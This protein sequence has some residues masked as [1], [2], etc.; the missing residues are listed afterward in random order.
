MITMT[1]PLYVAIVLFA[2]VRF[3]GEPVLDIPKLAG[4]ISW[5]TIFFLAG[6]MMIA[7]AMGEATT[8]ISDWVMSW[9]APLVN[10]LS[11]F[12]MVALLAV[13]STV[14]TNICNNIPVGIVFTTVAVP[15]ALQMG[16]NP[17]IPA[18]AIIMGAQFAY[19]IPPAFVPIG[20]CYADKF[21]GGKYTFRWGVVMTLISCVVAGLLIYPLG[22]LVT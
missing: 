3:D 6:I 20:F 10:N 14:L 2:I 21:G 9:T 5:F 11:P 19:C 16:I 7:T 1:T 12:A 13:M 8:G 4:K 15:L 18:M 17:F 22:M